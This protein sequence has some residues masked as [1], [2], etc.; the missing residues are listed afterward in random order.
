MEAVNVQA[1]KMGAQD[2]AFS[3]EESLGV[4]KVVVTPPPK[5]PKQQKGNRRQGR[6]YRCGQEGHLSKDKC[7]PARQSVCMKC[8]KVD[9]YA[10]VW[11]TN[12]GSY[13]ASGNKSSG[14]K[15]KFGETKF[16]EEVVGEDTDDDEVLGIFTAKGSGKVGRTPIHVSV[17]LD[18]KSCKMQLDTGASVYLA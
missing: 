15:S 5:P 3:T 17:M 1:K 7:C 13:S 18:Q 8:K 2:S 16:V 11:K 6:C 9:H 4:N 12:P 14:R 10:S